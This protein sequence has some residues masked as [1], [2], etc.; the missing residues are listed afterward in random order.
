VVLELLVAQD[1]GVP[2]GSKSWDG[3]TSAITVFQERAQARLAAFQKAP[4]PRY[5][6]ADA[7]LSHEANAPTLPTLGWITRIPH[8]LSSVSQV[9]TQTL[10]WDTWHRLDDDTRDQGLEL[11]H[12]G[13]AQRWL[14]VQSDAALARAEATLT[15]ARPR[16][17]VAITKPL[18]H[19]QATRF[20][21]AEVAQDARAALAQ[22]WTYHQVDSSTLIAH[23]RSGGKGRPPTP[24]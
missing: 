21:T 3:H 1:G 2:C 9:I 16:A 23:K 13:M 22:R 20:Q 19:L 7:K 24:P 18:L 12:D 14:I 10:A 4:S 5:L 15:T 6:I 17:E 8:T 11:C